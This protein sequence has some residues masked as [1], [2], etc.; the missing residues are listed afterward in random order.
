MRK[1]LPDVNRKETMGVMI[2]SAGT[3]RTEFLALEKL[4][5]ETRI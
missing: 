1:W 2:I 5:K 3:A 4:H